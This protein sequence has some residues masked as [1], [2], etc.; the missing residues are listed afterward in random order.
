MPYLERRPQQRRRKP[1]PRSRT[2]PPVNVAIIGSGFMGA[3]HLDALRRVPNVN[4]VAI[5][6]P[7]PPRAN[8][9]AQQFGVPDVYEDWTQLLGRDDVQCVHNCTP[10]DLH[11]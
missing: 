6:S 4:V 11:F 5:A 10:N 1:E 9:L 8:E 7:A 2:M 3:A